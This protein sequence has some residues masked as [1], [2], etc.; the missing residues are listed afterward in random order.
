MAS[1]TILATSKP[2]FCYFST[3]GDCW[4]CDDLV[5]WHKAMVSAYSSDT[6]NSNFLNEWNNSPFINAQFDCRSSNYSF[7]N[8][9]KAVGIYDNLFNGLGGVIGKTNATAYDVFHAGTDIIDNSATTVSSFSKAIPY[10]AAGIVVLTIL[11][12]I[13]V[14]YSKSKTIISNG[15]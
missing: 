4:S 12:I 8:Y 10:I 15:K 7:E 1:S 6:A 2:V 9:F 11:A 3:S 13:S 14:V 5:T